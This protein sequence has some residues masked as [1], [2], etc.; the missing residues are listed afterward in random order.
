MKEFLKSVNIW[1]SYRQNAGCVILRIR[2]TRSSSKMQ[3]SPE[4][5]RQREFKVGRTS[6]VSRL[7]AFLTEANWWR[8]I[9]EWKRLEAER[10][11]GNQY[12]S[13]RPISESTQYFF[14]G[15]GYSRW[16]PPT[17]ILG[18]CPQRGWRQCLSRNRI[19]CILAIKSDMASYLPKNQLTTVCIFFYLCTE[20]IARERQPMLYYFLEYQVLVC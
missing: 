3:N 6:L 17:K 10:T 20:T 18:M 16:R 7:S 4:Q 9:A 19:W 11:E 12:W 8:L 5:W 14:L 2:L 1:Q 15:G 13:A